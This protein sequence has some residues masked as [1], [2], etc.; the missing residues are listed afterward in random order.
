METSAQP[1]GLSKRLAKRLLP[2]AL[3]IGC[4]ISLGLPVTFYGIGSGALGHTAAIYAHELARALEHLVLETQ[5]LWKYQAQKY[6]GLL[7]HFLPYKN[8][9]RIRVVD[10]TGHPIIGYNHITTETE[11]WW[12][13]RPPVGSAPITFNDR[14]VGTVEVYLSRKTLLLVTLGLFAGCI[15]VGVSLAVF[16]YAAPMRVVYRMEQH[17]TGLLESLQQSNVGLERRAIENAHLV[18]TLQHTLGDLKTKNTELDSFVYSVSHDLKAPLVTLQGMSS[19]LME[20]YGEKLD[21]EGRYYIERLQANTQHMERLLMDLLALS[22]VGREARAPEAV[23]LDEVVDDCL[24]EQAEPIRQRG[25]Q[26]RRG[27]LGTLWAV[28]THMVQVI[29]NLL[30]NAVKY[31]GDTPIPTVEIGAVDCG[32]YVEYFVKDNGIGIDPAYHT[33]IFEVFQRLKEIDV[34]GSGVGLAIVKKI[35]DTAGGRLRVESATGQGATFRFTWPKNLRRQDDAAKSRG[36][37][38][39]G[40]G[41]PRPCDVDDAGAEGRQLAQQGFLG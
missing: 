38:S 19:L 24:A 22:R 27:E 28:R 5:S 6:D 36:D 7:Q 2:L 30:G 3:V 16:V 21:E 23:S 15:A 35:V 11:V 1:I 33:K 4:C 25:V 29:G 10:E 13:L 12:N 37:D 32:A 14:T 26:V 34:D 18:E 17:I 39:A 41:Q 9:V 40:R 20:D 8:V 31:L